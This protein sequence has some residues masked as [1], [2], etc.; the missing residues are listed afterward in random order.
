MKLVLSLFLLFCFGNFYSQSPYA[1]PIDKTSGLPS[2][3][4]FDIYQDQKGFIWFATGKGLC[5]YDGIIVKSFTND[6]QTSK[7]GSCIQED[8]YGRIWYENF[9]G[10]LYYVANDKLYNFEPA[11]S[12]GYYKYGLINESL[13]QVQKNSVKIFDL[14][15]LQLSKE[16]KT[17]F[18]NIS[19]TFSTR[20]AFYVL[21]D[22]LHVFDTNGFE[23]KIQLPSDFKNRTITPI[24]EKY[25]NGFII[26]SKYS[27]Q[28]FIYE[29]EKFTSHS[30]PYKT[31]FIQNCAVFN[32]E[33]WICT[34]K[35]LLKL[36]PANN[37]IEHYFEDR[38]ISYIFKDKNNNYWVSTLSE[39]VFFIENFSTQLYSADSKPYTITNDNQDIIIG[40]E[41][42]EV[43]LFDT[44]NKK[45]RTIY[46]GNSNHPVG[47]LFSDIVTKNIF[48][49][50]SMFN[51]VGNGKLINQQQLALKDI[52]RIDE[53]YLAFA[54]TNNSGFI[55]T[56]RSLKSKWDQLMQKQ[57][58]KSI[59]DFQP[60]N[61]V[62]SSNGKSVA[63][64]P[65]NGT[66]YYATNKGL[67]AQTITGQKE[68]Q[69]QRNP[70]YLLKLKSYKN[71][72]YAL[73][74]NEKIVVIDAKNKITNFIMPEE[75]ITSKIENIKIQQETLFIFTNEQIIEYN[76]EKN[77]F[78][79]AITLTKDISVSDLTVFQNKIYFTTSKG[80]LIKD[81]E[82]LQLRYE[83]K[84]FIHS[85]A[86]NDKKI[87]FSKQ[88][89]LN[90]RQNNLKIDFSVLSA[91]PNQK[92]ALSY[93]INHSKWNK[94][95]SNARE[96]NLFSL[97]PG[98]Y[99]IYLKV[100][101]NKVPHET[102]IFFTIL[103]PFW[104]TN[105]FIAFVILLGL[106][107]VY[108]LYQLK[109][110]EIQRKNQL[111]L[112]KVNLEKNLNQSKLKALKSQM[113]PHFFYNAL[114]TLQSYILSN[115][116]K[117]AV[118][119]LAKFS[120][121]TRTI[122]E[123]TEK[124]TTVLSDEIK[125]LKLYLE[126]EKSRFDNDFTFDFVVDNRLDL[127]N[128]KI[129]SMLLQPYVENA[130]KHGLLHK[131]GEKHLVITFEKTQNFLQVII[132]DNGIGRKKSG[133]L[134]A[135]KNKTHQSFAT[136]AIQ[137]RIDLLNNSTNEPI[138]ICY[139]DKVNYSNQ[140]TG[141][142]VYFK[143]PLIY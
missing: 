127:D 42:D 86:A 53:K 30:I 5:R 124:D 16:I 126:I 77:T 111:V 80:L 32:D 83:P 103:K 116:K 90:F 117:E 67:F 138:S 109:L 36:N 15:T 119:Y 6:N 143:F 84:L 66:I 112:D 85:V 56:N 122:L 17:N 48:F 19:F 130:V 61:I 73:T 65:S 137:N 78:S 23:K 99:T 125:T 7:S 87:D 33:V 100:G 1:Y 141:T 63:Y 43:L 121:L 45:C 134:N 4:V 82:G 131:E 18:K 24:V 31:G 27:E 107:F 91:M 21:D 115:D 69:Y 41:K 76:L 22:Q 28:Y 129:P 29:N 136:K 105:L 54:A 20:D 101:E 8:K 38:S 57:A 71:L 139:E 128:I 59:T 113:N 75:Y 97:S 12:S 70:L 51:V 142:K 108:F 62:L 92:N 98:S 37:Q 94:L 3:S 2:N 123:M 118:N 96:L 74:S 88:P 93:K 55:E 132:E 49:T 46:N 58:G 60:I 39:G 114:N 10:F 50:S 110:R 64:N 47:L 135:I 13:F 52:V 104:Q 34:P 40:T 133:E 102:M 72:I 9:D 35:G 106:G 14:K 79:T 81:S 44:Q 25:K 26:F 11:I 89:E 120:S 95:E 140:S 68:V